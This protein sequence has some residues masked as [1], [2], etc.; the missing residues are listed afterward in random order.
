M[1]SE[2]RKQKVIELCQT[3]VK[4]QS[5]SGQENL[6][7][8]EI[9]NYADQ[10][11]FDEV[12]IDQYGNVILVLNGNQLG[13]TVLFDGHI[14]TVPVQAE[15]WTVDP[16]SGEIKNGKIYG[17]GTTD[18][19][20]A[21]SAMISACI[22]FAE[23]TDKSFPGKIVIS[24]SV[25]EEC[26]EGVATRSVSEIIKPDYVVIGEATNLNLNRGQRGRA[27][28]VIET[29]GKPVHSSNPQRGINAVY[30]MMKLISAIKELPVNIHDVLGQGILE[31]TDI[32]SSPYPGASVVPSSCKATFDRRLLVGE[33]KESVLSP[34][35]SVIDQLQSKD[36]DF[37]ATVKFSVGEERCY[38]DDIIGDERFFPGWLFEDEEGFVQAA[39]KGLISLGFPTQLSHYSFCTNGSHF[40]GEAGI[41]TIGFGPSLESLAHVDD[42]YIEIDQLL[43]ATAGYEAIMN[44]LTSINVKEK[45]SVKHV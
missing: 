38:T 25:H 30:Q 1:L 40:A 7:A 2:I 31:L 22:N 10:N 36:N 33:T 12:I 13:P 18:M 15:R 20:G 42:E 6:V 44:A 27:E 43:K 28:I 19:K 32:K 21:V 16:F 11:G 4:L 3:L 35:Q 41:P 34:I 5:Y 37:R 9:K 24:C 39:L 17:R 26:F 45:E 29:I 14:D 8:K 23:D